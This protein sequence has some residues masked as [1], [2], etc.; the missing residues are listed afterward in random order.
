MVSFL[1]IM[2]LISTMSML[3]VGHCS[4]NMQ[5][6][7]IQ[8]PNFII[9]TKYRIVDDRP[10]NIYIEGD[11]NAWETKTKL[12]SDPTPK[13][14]ESMLLAMIDKNPNVVYIARPGQYLKEEDLK[15]CSSDYWSLKRYS[16]DVVIAINQVI[17]HYVKEKHNKVHLIGFSG[18]GT[19]AAL[20]PFYRND[21]LSVTT[22]AGNLDHKALG[23]ITN[24]TLLKFSLNPQD[25]AYKYPKIPQ[26]HIIGN[27]DHLLKENI[28]IKFAL[29]QPHVNCIK[30]SIVSEQG[31]SNWS[32]LWLDLQ[33]QLPDC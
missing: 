10:I 16:E 21:I 18:G 1:K 20:L 5:D 33:Q 7:Y 27:K 12:S 9:F 2:V 19:I 29:T 23:F 30:I 14:P 11:G 32:K 3:H 4:I 26:H 6:N 22:V 8:T 25:F 17:D 28:T 24:T 15:K 31:H 13:N